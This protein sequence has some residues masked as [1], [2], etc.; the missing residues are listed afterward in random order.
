MKNMICVDPSSYANDAVFA[1]LR[2]DYY[3]LYRYTRH[4]EKFLIR[5]KACDEL[6]LKSK[7]DSY[8]SRNS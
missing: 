6:E 5:F 8:V 1:Y 7:W 3:S 2:G 4:S